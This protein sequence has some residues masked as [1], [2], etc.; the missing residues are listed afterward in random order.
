MPIVNRFADLSEEITEWRRDIHA[1][2]ELLY[3]VHR[4]AALV[5]E[6][7][8]AFGLDEVVPGIG[9]TGVV[10]VIKGKSDASGKVIGLRA[11]MDAL[12]I[13][14]ITGKPYASTVPGKMHA[15]GHDGHTAMLLGAAKYLS[16][17]RNFDGTVVVIFQPAEE[18]G[19][20]AKAM[21][22]DGL[23]TRF[24]IQ[25]VY[26]MHNMP[27]AP[28]GTFAIRPGPLMAAADRLT[29]EVEGKGCHAAKPHEGI[30]TILVASQII[31]SLQSI[32]SR[33][34]DPLESVVVSITMFNAGFTDNVI[35]QTATLRGTVRTLTPEMRDM[36]E[37]RVKRIATSVAEAYGATATVNYRR[38]YPVTVNNAEKMEFAASIAAQIVGEENVELNVPPTMGGED[39]A[40]MLE[41]RPGAFIFA[42]NGDSAMLHHPAY[43]FNDELIPVGCSYWVKLVET[44]LAAK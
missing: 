5:E 42:G 6:K 35:P 25:E 8:K 10:G 38:D 36:A 40:F 41:E 27:G 26:G 28:V 9:K 32:A 13:E 1:N 21:I 18:G 34:A 39:F 4:T 14:E 30:D 44:A 3:D 22:D 43:D 29:I 19:A 11:D 33:N 2:P 20:G 37:E 7:L 31:N 23:M 24:G 17:T 16:E 12:P 15:C